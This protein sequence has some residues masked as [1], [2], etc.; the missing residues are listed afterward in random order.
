MMGPNPLHPDR[1]SPAERRAELC[2]ILAAG[3]IRM[4]AAKSS[5]LSANL[6]ESSVD[7]PPHQSGHATAHKRRPA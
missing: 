5:F 1:T 6:G 4:M 3:L 7:F 2:R